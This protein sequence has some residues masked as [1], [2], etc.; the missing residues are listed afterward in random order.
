MAT[1][2]FRVGTSGPFIQYP[3]TQ[4]GYKLIVG[5]DGL[6][7]VAQDVAT[8]SELLGQLSIAEG[9]PCWICYE[10]NSSDQATLVFPGDQPGQLQVA[11]QF[12]PS[13]FDDVREVRMITDITLRKFTRLWPGALQFN[14]PSSVIA[15]SNLIPTSFTMVDQTSFYT[16]LGEVTKPILATQTTRI[17]GACTGAAS[18]IIACELGLFSSPLPPNE[19]GQT[20]TRIGSGTIDNTTTGS[21]QVDLNVAIDSGTHLWGGFRINTTGGLTLGNMRGV[22][23]DYGDCAVLSESASAV[24][25]GATTRTGSAIAFSTTGVSCGFRL[26][27]F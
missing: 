7:D 18:A 6:I 10:G 19:A 5:S 22:S 23:D 12:K 24:F 4:I 11:D 21:K 16:Y 27:V 25:A 2:K 1:S 9:R 17:K 3:A 20:L 13:Y 26:R 14:N 15:R 8:A